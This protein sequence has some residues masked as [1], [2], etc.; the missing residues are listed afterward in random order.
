MYGDHLGMMK[1][2]TKKIDSYIL[3]VKQV[4]SLLNYGEPEIL[5]LFKST[6]PSKLY[7]ILFPINNLRKAMETAKRVINKEKLDKQLT[8]QASSLSLF[9]KLGDDTSTPQQNM[10]NPQEIEAISSRVYNMSLQQDKIGK[11]FKPQVYQRRGRDQ[12]Q[13]YD[14]DRSRNNNR[15]GQN[16]GQNRCGNNYRRNGYMQNFSRNNGRGRGRNFNRNYSNDRSRSRERRLTPR[17]YN[18]NNNRQNTNSRLW[19]ESGRSRSRSRSNSRV[20]T[21]RDRIRCYRCR[22]YDHYASECQN[23]VVSDSEGYDSDNAALQ[24]MAT[25]IESDNTHDIERYREDTEY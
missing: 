14:R 24:I 9:M 2:K 3:K 25:E 15:Q 12:T 20:R 13:N 23:A 10:L 4:A 22:E 16:F 5:E 8:G 1:M 11:P 6:L 17:R 18:N 21:N 19:S 7:W